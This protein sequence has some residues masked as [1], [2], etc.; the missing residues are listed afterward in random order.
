MQDTHQFS[1]FYVFQLF[2]EIYLNA[3]FDSLENPWNFGLAEEV[4]SLQST[5]Q[6]RVKLQSLK[7]LTV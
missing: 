1:V 6:E 5:G 2:M 7:H 4:S 3:P